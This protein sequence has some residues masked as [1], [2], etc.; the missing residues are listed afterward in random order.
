M[1]RTAWECHSHQRK[2]GVRK[3]SQQAIAGI[4]LQ[5]ELPHARILYVSA[6]GATE[7][8]NL[9]YADRLGLW[10]EATPFADVKAFIEDVSRGGIASMELISRDMKA[11]GMYVSR[12]LSYD[13]VSYERLEHTLTELQ[14]DIY[15]ELA[16]AW[17]IVLNN[18]EQALEITQAGSNG[19]AKSAALS[20]FWG[21]HQRFFNQIITAMQ[22]PRV[23]D[24]IREQLDA[25]N[26]AVIQLG[27]HKRSGSGAHNC[28][29]HGK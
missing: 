27:K 19:N 24:D 5:H 14:E 6:T 13:G 7:I 23:I 11:L 29:C 28:R 17:Q 16:G 1:R 9:R 2:R 26:V 18:V 15:N 4:N 12:S 20:Q 3:P 8:S 25:G 22:T 21:A 10:G